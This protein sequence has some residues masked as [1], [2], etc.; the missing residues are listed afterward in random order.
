M[1]SARRTVLIVDDDPSVIQTFGRML[2]LTGYD[3]VT[4]LDAEAGL[5]AIAT[6]HPDAVLL[7]LRMPLVDGL[8][9]LRRLRADESDRRMP[10][11]IITGDYFIDEH[12]AREL[13][14]LDAVVF[15]KPVWLE[16]LVVITDRL[17]RRE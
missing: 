13:N 7:D 16:D 9:F 17:L 4:A 2:G 6:A 12:L 8:A 10:V 5:R 15:F 1:C 11:A 3:V 14:E